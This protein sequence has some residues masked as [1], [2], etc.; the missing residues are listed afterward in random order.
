MVWYWG[1]L[2]ILLSIEYDKVDSYRNFHSV[3]HLLT[4]VSF[5][6]LNTKVTKKESLKVGVD[7]W[8]FVTFFQD[9]GEKSIG[10]RFEKSSKIRLHLPQTCVIHAVSLGL[11]DALRRKVAGEWK[12]TLSKLQWNVHRDKL[13]KYTAS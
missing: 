2:T 13:K 9:T 5:E 6:K 10:P 12:V 3:L 8:Q 11:A 7:M 1:Y 4:A